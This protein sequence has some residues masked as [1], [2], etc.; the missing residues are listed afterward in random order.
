MNTPAMT[1]ARFDGVTLGFIACTIG[2]A[3]IVA[4]MSV[5]V[6]IERSCAARENLLPACAQPSIDA[7]RARIARDPGD[8]NAYTQLALS[9]HS[10]SRQRMLEIASRLAPREPN[11]LLAQAAAAM[12][13]EDWAAAVTPLVE[14][15]DQ[16][17]VA[18]AAQALAALVQ[19]GH[20]DLLL[21]HLRAHTTWLQH[22][23]L[24]MRARGVPLSGALPLVIRAAQLGIVD[25]ETVR[26]YVRDLK[27]RGAWADAHALWMSMHGTSVPLLFNASF[28]HAFELNGFDW[29]VPPAGTTRRAGV[30]VARRRAEQRGAVLELQFN[31][32]P[33][34][35]P[36]VRQYLFIAPGRYRLHGD[37]LGRQFRMEQG[38]VWIVRCAS[39]ASAGMSTPLRD[40]LGL[41]Q[42]FEFEFKVPADCGTVASL[43][44]ETST[45]G[46]AA[47]G[48]RGRMSFDAFSLERTGS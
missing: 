22:T 41:W 15:A 13:R 23:I 45:P 6:N 28:D 26:E 29:E 8:A 16:R 46:D 47:L 31:A 17:D 36:I 30:V 44:L 32:R 2:A 11:M 42:P 12:E 24:Q 39:N 35:Q 48:A 27:A 7:L 37:Y 21:P 1:L 43:Q 33:I 38:L 19:D 3:A 18:V 25:V 4:W 40:T 5:S 10:A 34:A 20:A 9:D 14:L